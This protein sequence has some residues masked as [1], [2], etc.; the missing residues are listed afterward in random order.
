MTK[1]QAR[2]KSDALLA[3][4]EEERREA[5]EQAKRRDP[6]AQFVSVRWVEGGGGQAAALARC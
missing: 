4:E 6:D 5:D 2:P 3:A 1:P